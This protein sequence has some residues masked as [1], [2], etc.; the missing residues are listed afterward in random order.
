METKSFSKHSIDALDRL[1]GGKGSV[2][3][4]VHINPDGDALG[5]AT[6]MARYLRACRGREAWVVVPTVFSCTLDFVVDREWLVD[7][8]AEPDRAAQLVSEASL[9]ICQDMN[10]FSRSGVLSE[11]LSASSAEKILIDHHLSPDR[12]SFDLVFS[13][14][15]ISSASELL[16]QILVSLPDIGAPSRLPLEVATPLM[17]GMT[18][19]TNNFA[20]SV[21]PS[22]LSMASELLAVGVD[23]NGILLHLYNEYREN[24][25]RAMGHC[26]ADLMKITPEGVA[27]IV[28]D[29]ASMTSL[30]LEE[31]E[32]EGFVNIPLGIAHVRMSVFLKQD[33]GFFRVSVRSKPGTSANAFASTW[34]HGGGHECASGGRL[35]FP[36]DIASSEMAAQY[37]ENA[38]ARFMQNV[39]PEPNN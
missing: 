10:S 22:T 18:T 4:A 36:G 32:T 15:E 9:I 38:A 25:Y 21:F 14:T 30:G 20:N 33:D 6:A 17:V 7:A 37:I 26:L 31:G 35:F 28:L 24:R 1:L 39:T 12:E 27:Y 16:Y 23:R 11:P 2:V 3:V 13:E 29:A 8:G 34:F 5:S 19:D